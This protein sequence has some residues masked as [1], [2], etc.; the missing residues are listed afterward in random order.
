MPFEPLS[1]DEVKGLIRRRLEGLGYYVTAHN[2][3]MSANMDGN[4][5][6]EW[7]IENANPKRFEVSISS[8]DKSHFATSIPGHGDITLFPEKG[9]YH[10]FARFRKEDKGVNEFM[11]WL[12]RISLNHQHLLE[13]LHPESLPAP[14]KFAEGRFSDAHGYHQGGEITRAKVKGIVSIKGV[15]LVDAHEPGS[16]AWFLVEL[17]LHRGQAF[18]CTDGE[19]WHPIVQGKDKKCEEYRVLSRHGM[20][21]TL[22]KMNQRDRELVHDAVTTYVQK[23]TATDT[24]KE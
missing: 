12:A 2:I 10:T 4:N 19:V 16:N 1:M 15:Q 9:V 7:K 5:K 18:I 17:Q 6:M 24:P 11:E 22:E 14:K 8:G 3:R 20:I 13:A 21:D 23:V